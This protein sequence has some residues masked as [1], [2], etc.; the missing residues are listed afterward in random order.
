MS[1]RLDKHFS[2]KH[3]FQEAS[4]SYGYWKNKSITERLHAA[5]FLILTTWGFDPN[6]PPKLDRSIFSMKKHRE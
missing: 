5:N 1:Y 4:N 6:Q 2:K 3:T